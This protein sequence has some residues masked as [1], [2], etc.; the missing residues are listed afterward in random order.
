[1]PRAFV[2]PALRFTQVEAAGGLV[3]LAAA[4]VALAVGQL[5]VVP[6]LRGH[7]PCPLRAPAGPRGAAR[8]GRPRAHQRRA[9]DA[10]L[11]AGRP[12]DQAP[13]GHRRAPRPA[14]RGAPRDRRPRRHGRAGAH[15]HRVQRRPRRRRRLGHP[16][17]DGHRVRCRRRDAGRPP[18]PTGRPHLHP[19]PGRRRRRRRDRRHRGLLCRGRAAGLARAGRAGG[20]GDRRAAPRGGPFDR[21]LRRARR[22]LLVRVAALRRRGRH[23]RRRVRPPD[24]HP[25]VPRSQPLR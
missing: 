16:G 1:M 18:R 5:A 11:P 4:I 17:G 23:R 7:A 20:R 12:R 22:G 15:L 9:D 24:P 10:V 14:C 3:M 2:R 21:A 13:A 19:H 25:T 6:R 8:H